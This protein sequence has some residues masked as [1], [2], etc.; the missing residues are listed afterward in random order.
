MMGVPPAERI[1]FTCK[2]Y[3]PSKLTGAGFLHLVK[4]TDLVRSIS[5][6]P[7]SV[8]NGV[9][10]FL[11]N[12][13]FH[14]F[15]GRAPHDA[16]KNSFSETEL[17]TALSF[18]EDRTKFEYLVYRFMFSE[19]P[20]RKIVSDFPL[21]VAIEPTSL[22]NL[23]CTMC[24]QADQGYF[25][26][27]NPLMG[28]MDFD[29]YKG[30]IDEM[31]K[32]QPCGLVLASRGEPL[33]HKRFT[34]MVA[35]ATD[36]GIIDVKINTNATALTEKR[37]RELLEAEPT[38]IVFSVDA[39][40]KKEFEAIRVGANFDQV[41][42]N[43]RKFNEIREREFPNSSTRTRISMTIFRKTQDSKEAETL[44][45]PMV[46][47]FA[48]HSADFRL[49]IYEHPLVEETEPC[50][51]LWERIYIW[52]DGSVNPCDMDY[53]SQLCLGRVGNGQ[54]IKSVWL[55]DKMQQ[56][57]QNHSGGSKNLHS[58]CNRCYG[59]GF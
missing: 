10:R 49:D 55:G 46:D 54:T 58:P 15:E 48:I 14:S 42:A 51:L 28:Y 56:M 25:N 26:R 35:Y 29:L 41:V 13:T 18:V 17:E 2:R 37:V 44:W 31:I 21:I 1:R 38:T 22:C 36:K 19:F 4:L 57:R 24:F 59:A 33:L 47:E 43:I 9:S 7:E 6:H 39:G 11:Q 16:V 20:A 32:N 12:T 40:N 45:S 27:G 52:W 8:I 23:R 3:R 53:K 30:L 5:L 34:E 50:K